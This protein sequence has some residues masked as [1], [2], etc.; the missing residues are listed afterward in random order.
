MSNLD[1]N[2]NMKLNN[3]T[4]NNKNEHVWDKKEHWNKIP[5]GGSNQASSLE[6]DPKHS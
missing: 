5:A 6:N 1:M 3:W 4:T 2:M